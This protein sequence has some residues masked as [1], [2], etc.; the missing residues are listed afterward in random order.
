[1]RIAVASQSVSR[2]PVLRKELLELFPDCVFNEDLSHPRPAELARLLKDC[3]GAVVGLEPI[4]AELL[5]RCPKLKI[6]SKYGVGLD[7][8]DMA[9]CARHGVMVGWTPGL[10]RLAVA[11]MALGFMIALLRHMVSSCHKLKQG[12]WEKTVG[13]ELTGKTVGIV[14]LGHVGKEVARL[15]T[16]FH[17]RVLANDI[18][19]IAA[20]C[21]KHG[22]EPATKAKIWRQADIVTLHTPLTPRTRGMVGRRVLGAMKNTAFLVNTARGPIVDPSALKWALKKGVIAGA[23][24]D[25]YSAEPPSDMD[26]LGIPHLVCTPH[27]A[28]SSREA[29]LA[30]GRSAIRHLREF[31]LDGRGP[32]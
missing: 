26:L 6:V 30:M 15:L 19:D 1:M 24:L 14:G 31:F 4:G 22:L 2:H 7:N 29:V 27:R 9:A 8:V 32:R 16:P 23:A 28:G 18:V 20:Y 11:E 3:D 13:T 17:C 25:V 12:C 10:N 5:C 21:R